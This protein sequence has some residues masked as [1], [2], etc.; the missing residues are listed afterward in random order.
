MEQQH[1]PFEPRVMCSEHRHLALEVARGHQ[2]V[3]TVRIYNGEIALSRVDAR[4]FDEEYFLEPPAPIPVTA[5]RFARHLLHLKQFPI[6]EGAARTLV[7]I[8][9]LG[10]EEPRSKENTAILVSSE[11]QFVGSY[12][13][14]EDAELVRK[15]VPGFIARHRGQLEQW[16]TKV[17]ETLK[18]EVAPRFKA[19]GRNQLME[20]VLKMAKNAAK[21]DAPAVSAVEKVTKQRVPKTDGPVAK[22]KAYVEANAAALRGGGL[23]RVQAVDALKALGVNKG[24]IGVQLGKQL[25][26]MGIEAAKGSRAK[27]KPDKVTKP[28]TEK[29]TKPKATK[30]PGTSKKTAKKASR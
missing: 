17:F 5:R 10:T 20:G 26:A 3:A 8:M 4:E 28:K 29:V 1:R 16:P 27:P 9:A 24:T 22:V 23:T 19:K 6:Q 15:F 14:V 18:Q 13:T 12:E 11:G 2:Q 25:K 21:K 30:K 7:D